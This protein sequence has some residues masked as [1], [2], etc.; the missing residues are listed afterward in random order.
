MGAGA[1]DPEQLNDPKYAAIASAQYGAL[2]PGN[3]MKMY[4]LEPS[5]GQY[6]FS[7]ADTVASF[8]QDHGLHVTASAPI[9]DGTRRPLPNGSWSQ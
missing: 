2:E 3:S 8:A 9:W 1:S 6:S 5:E 4:A 7:S